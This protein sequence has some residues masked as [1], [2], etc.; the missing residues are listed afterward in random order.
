DAQPGGKGVGDRPGE[1]ELVVVQLLVELEDTDGRLLVGGDVRAADEGLAI[2]RRVVK[3]KEV[4]PPFP[5]GVLGQGGTGQKEHA[6]VPLPEPPA[7]LDHFAVGAGRL[8]VPQLLEE[9]D[10]SEEH[11]SELQSREN[12]VCRLLLE[13]K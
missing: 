3:E 8:L 7:H 13:K 2:A 9:I 12:L 6:P 10:R 5:P 11:T 1:E 4:K